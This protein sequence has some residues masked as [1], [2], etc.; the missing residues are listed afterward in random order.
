MKVVFEDVHA[1]VEEE[2]TLE[3]LRRWPSK[4]LALWELKSGKPVLSLLSPRLVALYRRLLRKE[5]GL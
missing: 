4:W 5:G 3:E 1:V 2:L